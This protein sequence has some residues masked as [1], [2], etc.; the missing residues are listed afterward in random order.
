MR[1]KFI[2]KYAKVM[3]AHY[4]LLAN[5]HFIYSRSLLNSLRKKL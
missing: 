1:I 4:D 3:Q 2:K 5:R